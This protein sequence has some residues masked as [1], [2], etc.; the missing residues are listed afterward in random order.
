[1]SNNAS[2]YT[3]PNNQP[4]VYLECTSAF[5]ALTAKEKLYAH[6]L[7]QASWNGSLITFIQT[8]PESPL[9]F[10]LLHKVFLAEPIDSLKASALAAG[11]SEDEF[12]VRIFFNHTTF[13][14][15]QLFSTFF[16]LAGIF[17][18]CKRLLFERRQLQ[19]LW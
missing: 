17:S 16:P 9:L 12:I 5:N 6:Y 19:V 4:V 2:L 14:S 8:S 7:S 15:T 11:V 1:M 3:L 18:F 13:I 10:A